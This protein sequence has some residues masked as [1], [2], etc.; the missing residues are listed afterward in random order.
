MPSIFLRQNLSSEIKIKHT[1]YSNMSQGG[2]GGP[3]A[4]R[5]LRRSLSGWKNFKKNVCGRDLR[6]SKNSKQSV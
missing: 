3:K 4:G 5:S 1:P 2:M 6:S